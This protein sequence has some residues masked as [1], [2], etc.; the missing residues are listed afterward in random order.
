MMASGLN[1]PL[2]RQLGVPLLLAVVATGLITPPLLLLYRRRLSVWMGR[3]AGETP[4]AA[5]PGSPFRA[6]LPASER[7][8]RRSQAAVGARA[9][10]WFLF[11]QLVGGV[12]YPRW[13]SVHYMGVDHGGFHNAVMVRGATWP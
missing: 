5:L 2:M 11:S 7:L 8:R 3:K 12:S 1:Y 4:P 10:A 6:A 9:R 13:P